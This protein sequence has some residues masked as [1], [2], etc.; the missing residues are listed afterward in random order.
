MLILEEIESEK[1]DLLKTAIENKYTISFWYKGVRFKNP[2]DRQYVRQGWRFVQ[3]TGLGLSPKTGKMMLRA[4]QD[5]GT[6]NTKGVSNKGVPAWKTF[7]VDEM[8]SITVMNGNDGGYKSFQ[9]P[10]GYNFNQRGD[11][12][13]KGGQLLYKIDVNKPLPPDL[14][15]QQMNEK[16]SFLKWVI[17]DILNM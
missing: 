12:K 6:S 17:N 2:N 16:H 11:G 8:S 5:G 9:K 4:W 14:S 7:L 1:M 15:K 3:P 10:D 13:M